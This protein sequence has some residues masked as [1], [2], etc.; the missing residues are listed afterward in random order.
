MRTAALTQDKRRSIIRTV[1]VIALAI[2]LVGEGAPDI[3]YYW[4][5]H[6]DFGITGMDS[7]GSLPVIRE[8]A[9]H[10]AAADAGLQVGDQIE[11]QY[12][13]LHEALVSGSWANPGE[14][15]R[16]HV[17]RRGKERIV[18]LVARPA[19]MSAASIKDSVWG[20]ITALIRIALG[21]TLVLIRPGLV[22]WLF[23][24]GLTS[25]GGYS[26]AFFLLPGWL[27][28]A[29]LVPYTVLIGAA[30][31]TYVLFCLAF[32]KGDLAGWRRRVFYFVLAALV[33]ASAI[34]LARLVLLILKLDTIDWI[35]NVEDIIGGVLGVAA[36]L[37]YFFGSRGIDRERVRWI[38]IIMT[39]GML[40]E[41]V[42]DLFI[43]V[44][45]ASPMVSQWWNLMMGTG[46]LIPLVFAYA[47]FR[48]QMFDV[49][50]VLSRALVY[51]LLA[52]AAIGVFLTIDLAFA[53]RFHGSKA[54]FAVDIAVALGIGFWVRAI[55]SR[56]IDLVDRVFF[57][58]R[59]ESRLR[60][61]ATSNLLA[62]AD[63][64]RAVEEVVTS[65]A[66][67]S[68]GLASAV[69]F[70]C[71]ADG[72]LLREVGFG[73][74]P[75]APWHLLPDDVVVKTL[76]KNAPRS[77]DLQSLPW[78]RAGAT[79]PNQP[80]VA[81]PMQS[82]QRLIGVTFYGSRLNGV[83]P[84]PD[85]IAALVELAWRAASVYLLLDSPRSS[86]TTP[87]LASTRIPR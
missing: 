69:F 75:T 67:S 35:T 39:I 68:L 10:S 74:P 80:V 70:R 66:A 11:T 84:A 29:A 45:P 6:G 43:L 53:S 56:A 22:T 21:V 79:P 78:A 64:T 44:S 14:T 25:G 81:V 41:V 47:I 86:V 82:G 77:I 19:Y 26:N 57:R 52:A 3:P 27:F 31:F 8:L 50:F 37:A 71:V 1:V 83:L 62:A 48:Y 34:E 87:E 18:T 5:P 4:L 51:S 65:N 17:L 23:Y 16:M 24:L 49:E 46:P 2:Y 7:T 59:F 42:Y 36:L 61:R 20:Q 54:E 28:V 13:S 76:T 38:V 15:L 60:V 73:W 12:L 40:F 85:E 55:H 30:P 32:P 58:R 9:A 33:I 63:S 72:G